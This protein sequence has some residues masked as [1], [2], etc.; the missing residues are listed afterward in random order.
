MK[1]QD[2]KVGGASFMP[3]QAQVNITNQNSV[4]DHVP[5]M[6]QAKDD[7]NVY[8]FYRKPIMKEKS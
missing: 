2:L 6:I 7:Q 1:Q 8:N 5:K 3:I 4:L